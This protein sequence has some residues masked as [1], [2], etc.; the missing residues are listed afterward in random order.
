MK[1]SVQTDAPATCILTH[2]HLFFLPLRLLWIC[3][4]NT[5]C[6]KVCTL[7]LGLITSHGYMPSDESQTSS[8]NAHIEF[9]HHN[10]DC[11]WRRAWSSECHAGCRCSS[12]LYI[13]HERYQNREY[14]D[15]FSGL[16][17][18]E[19][20]PCRHAIQA[21]WHDPKGHFSSGKQ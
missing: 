20:P 13:Q 15:G 18:R 3:N 17:Q 11:E 10:V 7:F 19:V 8:K 9:F 2:A 5:A 1:I 14:H 16:L 6:H 21:K 12:Q 4:N